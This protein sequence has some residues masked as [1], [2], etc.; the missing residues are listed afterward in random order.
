MKRPGAGSVATAERRTKQISPKSVCKR[1][2][3]NRGTTSA[4]AKH[5]KACGTWRSYTLVHLTNAGVRAVGMLG[6]GPGLILPYALCYMPGLFQVR[7]LHGP[8]APPLYSKDVRSLSSDKRCCVRG[9]A[10]RSNFP[11]TSWTKTS[12]GNFTHPRLLP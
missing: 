1:G 4:A 11:K 12:D 3:A 10:S 9:A 8:K 2:Q 6:R 7:S 5:T